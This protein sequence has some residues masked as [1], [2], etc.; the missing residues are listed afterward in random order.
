[1]VCTF[2]GGSFVLLGNNFSPDFGFPVEDTDSIETLLVGSSSS[3]DNDLIGVGVVVDGAV[4]AERGTLSG[5][6]DLLP[7]FLG[8]VVGP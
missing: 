7:G 6:G 1:M 8:G 3:E 2:P 5:G 4:G